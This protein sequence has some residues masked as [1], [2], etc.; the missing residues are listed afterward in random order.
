[1]SYRVVFSKTALKMMEKLDPHISA[2]I[3]GWIRKNLE[4]CADPKAHGKPLKGNRKDEWR[5]RIGNY[6]VLAEI[7]EA[8]ILIYVL[9]VGH[10]KDI[11]H[12]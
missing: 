4:G 11:Y 2:L 7:R 8:E 5:Y 12:V 10:R 3:I 1:M 6:R 9:E